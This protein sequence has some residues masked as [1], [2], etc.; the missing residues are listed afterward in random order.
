MMFCIFLTLVLLIFCMFLLYPVYYLH[1]LLQFLHIVIAHILHGF[2][3]HV[4]MCICS[5]YP[6]YI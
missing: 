3:Q 2:V 4:H 6:M 1:I 5:A